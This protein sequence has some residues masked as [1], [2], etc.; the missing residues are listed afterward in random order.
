[1]HNKRESIYGTEQSIVNFIENSYFDKKD[2]QDLESLCSFLDNKFA[3]SLSSS[4]LGERIKTYYAKEFVKTLYL[5]HA[6]ECVD[7]TIT[8]CNTMMQCL[9]IMKEMNE[10]NI[11]SKLEIQS[12]VENTE[13]EYFFPGIMFVIKKIINFDNTSEKDWFEYIESFYSDA[14]HQI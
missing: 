7:D 10:K 1:M 9:E 11:I 4:V 3:C 8:Q 2:L 12:M 6:E 13:T 5:M 14:Y